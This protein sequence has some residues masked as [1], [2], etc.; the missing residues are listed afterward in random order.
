VE[1]ERVP[2]LSLW[3][4]RVS[5]IGPLSKQKSSHPDLNQNLKIAANKV[6]HTLTIVTRPCRR[7]ESSNWSWTHRDLICSQCSVDRNHSQSRPISLWYRWR[8]RLRDLLWMMEVQQDRDFMAKYSC[9]RVLHLVI[10]G[11]VSVLQS[12][13]MINCHYLEM[14]LQNIELRVGEFVPPR[15]NCLLSPQLSEA[16]FV[17]FSVPSSVLLNAFFYGATIYSI[18]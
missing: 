6:L 13:T 2:V 8:L 12:K 16:G 15:A 1:A 5:P 18:V 10:S 17:R 9:L 3:P 11:V 7:C 4:G 14:E